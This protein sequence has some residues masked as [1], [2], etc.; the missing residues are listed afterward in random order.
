MGNAAKQRDKIFNEFLQD[1][2][3][4][5]CLQIGVKDDV[6][7]KFGSNWVSVDKYDQRDFIDY[8]YDIHDLKFEDGTFDAVVC[9]SILEHVPYPLKAI[10]E[11]RRVLKPGGK[12]WIQLPFQMYYHEAPKDYWR[13]SPD[14]LRIWMKDFKEIFCGNY[15]WSR[16]SLVTATFFYGSKL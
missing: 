9:T 7:K 13:V 15:L 16:T 6:G 11:L 10:E 14:G 3:D 12:I 5:Q 2:R 4:K 1:C 8:H